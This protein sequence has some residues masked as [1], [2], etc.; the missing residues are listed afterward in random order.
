MSTFA[1]VPGPWEIDSLVSIP[2]YEAHFEVIDRS[3]STAGQA[4][5]EP[6]KLDHNSAGTRGGGRTT[7]ELEVQDLPEK[8][9]EIPRR[10]KR[11]STRH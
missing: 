7:L 5:K 11:A 3:T 9:G 8:V 2:G 6:E 1:S 10:N 4:K